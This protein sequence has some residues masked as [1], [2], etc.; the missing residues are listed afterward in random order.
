MAKLRRPS[1]LEKYLQIRYTQI[2]RPGAFQGARSLYKA[3]KNENRYDITL[4]EITKFLRG[5]DSWSIYRQNRKHFPRNCILVTKIGEQYQ[6]DLIDFSKDRFVEA[7]DNKY[8]YILVVQDVLSHYIYLRP[9]ESKASN[10][11]KPAMK[12]VFDERKCENLVTDSGVEFCSKIMLELYEAY[13]VKLR[14]V[15][16]LLRWRETLRQLNSY[17]SDSSNREIHTDMTINWTW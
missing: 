4:R 10:F 14:A 17:S 1:N 5:Q 6:A 2:G 7:N 12:S 11:M 8:R 3:L 15:T 13:D 9:V 16:R